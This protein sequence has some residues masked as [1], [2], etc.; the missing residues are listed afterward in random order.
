MKAVIFLIPL[1][2]SSLVCANTFGPFQQ[3]LNQ[4][5][6]SKSLEKGGFETHFDYQKARSAPQT[7]A[8]LSEQVENLKRI[9]LK[10]L[11]DKNQAIAFWINAYNFYM[12]KVILENGFENGKLS[13][14]SVKDLGTFFN[15]YKIFKQK[16]HHVGDQTLSLDDMEKGI[17]LGEGYKANGWKDARIH[18]AVNCASV[19]CPPLHPKIY[20]AETLDIVLDNN[21]KKAFLTPRHFHIKGKNLYLTH[22]FKWYETDFIESA[23]SVKKFILKYTEAAKIREQVQ[24]SQSIEYIDYDWKLNTPTNF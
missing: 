2:F 18:F 24:T 23:G 3:I 22:L 7:Q 8:L 5:L 21:V 4:S 10:T 11:K 13:I 17:L 6:T 15:P 1:F 9:N 12:V 14:K 19:G 20:E 16:D